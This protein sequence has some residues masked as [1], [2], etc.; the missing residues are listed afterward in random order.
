MISI[1]RIKYA[2]IAL[3][4]IALLLLGLLLIRH[5]TLRG[6]PIG[7]DT[8][9]EEITDEEAAVADARLKAALQKNSISSQYMDNY[10][11]NEGCTIYKYASDTV[12][13]PEKFSDSVTSLLY[14]E[15]DAIKALNYEVLTKWAN[16]KDFKVKE[17]EAVSS[18][19]AFDAYDIVHYTYA[20]SE[21]VARVYFILDMTTRKAKGYLEVSD[22]E[23]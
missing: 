20:N 1:S 12:I 8:D 19:L 16:D 18:E 11:G 6:V 23:G 22:V 2:L 21:Q 10:T 7:N 3:C 4:I 17:I 13:K 5:S 15:S 14:N 9:V